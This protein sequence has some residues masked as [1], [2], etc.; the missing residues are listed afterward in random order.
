MTKQNVKEIKYLLLGV[1]MEISFCEL[2][3]KEVINVC[4]GKRLGRVIDLVISLHSCK[5]LGIVVPGNKKIFNT[6]EDIFISWNNI[7]KIGVDV[8]LVQLTLVQQCEDKNTKKNSK[9]CKSSSITYEVQ[10]FSN[11][12]DFSVDDE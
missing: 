5:V 10:D 11:Q 1:Y 3:Q 7:Q 4:D 6:R 9:Q 12:L 8:L 2:R